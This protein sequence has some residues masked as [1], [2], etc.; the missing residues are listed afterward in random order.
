MTGVMLQY[1]ANPSSPRI[2]SAMASGPIGAIMT[3]RQG[4]LLPPGAMFCIDNGCGPGADGRPGSGYPGDRAYLE[5]LSRMSARARGRC[6]FATAPDVLGDAAATLERSAPFVY[7]I[8]AWFGLPVAL[9]AQDGL[10]RLDVPWSWFDV[11]FLGGSTGW[12]LGP[13]AADL[14]AEAHRRGKLVHMGRVNTLQRLRYAAH[15]GCDS[16]DGTTLTRAPDK[17]LAQMLRWL[18]EIH[19]QLALFGAVA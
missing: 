7:K 6:L 11:L 15:I 19:G 4:N 13:L 3:P 2:R 9:V 16:A 12:K 5:L 1:L 17:N 8:R 10:E 14:T 18:D